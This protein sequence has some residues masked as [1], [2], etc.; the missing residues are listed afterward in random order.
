MLIIRRVTPQA[1]PRSVA[2]GTTPTD[3]GSRY[4]PTRSARYIC[5]RSSYLAEVLKVKQ[6]S[7]FARHFGRSPDRLGAEEIRSYHRP[8]TVGSIKTM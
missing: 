6:V 7:Y 2:P 1:P 8:F 4:H 5:N 3:F